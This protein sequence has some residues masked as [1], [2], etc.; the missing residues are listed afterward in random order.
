MCSIPTNSLRGRRNEW[1]EKATRMSLSHSAV[2]CGA[3]QN[4]SAPDRSGAE[5][6]CI[7]NPRTAGRS[8]CTPAEPYPPNRNEMINRG[9]PNSRL[10]LDKPHT[11]SFA[12][13][14][15][16]IWS[17]LCRAVL[18]VLTGSS[19]SAAPAP[20]FP[21]RGDSCVIFE[22]SVLLCSTSGRIMRRPGQR[23]C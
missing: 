7:R 11:C 8:G 22:S 4:G 23:V 19:A 1:V 13:N 3:L 18:F 17:R 10:S 20:V 12:A 9:T 14:H 21:E 5:R 16:S 15:L 2:A 6:G